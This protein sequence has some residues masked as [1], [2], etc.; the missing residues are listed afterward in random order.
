MTVLACLA[1]ATATASTSE[2]SAPI[3]PFGPSTWLTNFPAPADA[4]SSKVLSGDVDGDGK[5]DGV[6]VRS[7]VWYKA[8][9]TGS[10]FSASSQLVP[11]VGSAAPKSTDIHLLADLNGNGTADPVRIVNGTWYLCPMI[12]EQLGPKCITSTYSGFGAQSNSELNTNYVA[13]MNSDGLADLVNCAS[14]LWRVAFK[15][16]GGGYGLP[17]AWS[18]S[19]G[20]PSYGIP[21]ANM[22]GDVDGDGDM[23]LVSQYYADWYVYLNTGSGFTLGTLWLS[24]FGPFARNFPAGT[25]PDVKL[26]RV[27]A[28]NTYDAILVIDGQW[29]VAP[30]TGTAFETP[31]YWSKGFRESTNSTSW[32]SSNHYLVDVDAVGTFHQADAVTVNNGTWRVSNIP[33]A[34]DQIKAATGGWSQTLSEDFNPTIGPDLDPAT[35][36]NK[37]RWNTLRYDYWYT[38]APKGDAISMPYDGLHETTLDSNPT[39]DK[40]TYTPANNSVS[41]GLLVQQLGRTPG[42]NNYTIGSVNTLGQVD[43]NGS[44]LADTG[45]RFKGG[46]VEARVSVPGCEGC[47][48]AFWMAPSVPDGGSWPVPATGYCGYPAEI[49]IFEYFPQAGF[50]DHRAYFNTHWGTYDCNPPQ[51]KSTAN[52][53]DLWSDAQSTS[54]KV[55]DADLTAYFWPFHTYGMLWYESG[56]NPYIQFFVD[57]IPGPKITQGLPQEKMYLILTLQHWAGLSTST[58][59]ATQMK[60]DYV[61]VYQ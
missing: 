41:N 3:T 16:P 38:G 34:P 13:D 14:G 32:F 9:S 44:Y 52:V 28:N 42:T 11:A 46:Y 23:D 15:S 61:R 55:L 10:A 27:D 48:P 60:T 8:L 54:K 33:T 53:H 45:T 49:D 26:A 6:V 31:L 12:V 1:V 30:S 43:A 39:G 19:A 51:P 7:G 25:P 29:W 18:S 36:L 50:N 56:P 20:A 2:A 35:G 40:A 58:G 24:G 57:G 37:R 59:S 17:S 47:W 4:S 21:H 5:S 22:L